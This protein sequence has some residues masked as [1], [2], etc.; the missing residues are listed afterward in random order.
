MDEDYILRQVIGSYIP[1]DTLHLPF[2]EQ[3]GIIQQLTGYIV[4]SPVVA[5]L[6]LE[7]QELQILVDDPLVAA[8]MRGELAEQGY[9][10]PE[11]EDLRDYVESGDLAVL[12]RVPTNWELLEQL[13]DVEFP[14]LLLRAGT[15]AA[16]ARF[17]ELREQV[18]TPVELDIAW[19][20]ALQAGDFENLRYL[21]ELDIGLWLDGPV[22]HQRALNMTEKQMRNAIA[23]ER[24]SREEL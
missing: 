7:L 17:E 24:M 18:M 3:R 1:A 10:L 4:S 22:D 2:V 5:R 12:A 16:R 20:A 23:Y 8:R 11:A 19:F 13:Y 9:L 15:S 6:Y 14:N 21:D